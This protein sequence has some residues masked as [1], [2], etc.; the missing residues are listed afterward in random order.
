[1]SILENES[2]SEFIVPKDPRPLI[3]ILKDISP[4]SSRM[5][6][7]MRDAIT[8]SGN[9]GVKPHFYKYFFIFLIGSLL[10]SITL[11]SCSHPVQNRRR[12]PQTIEVKTADQII[13]DMKTGLR[14]SDEQEADIRPIIEEQVK[15][16]KELVKKYQ[17]RARLGMDSL[18][19]DLKDLRITT[20]NQLQ[21]FLT[22]EQMINYGYMQQEEDLRITGITNGKT[23]EEGGREKPKSGGRR[24]GRF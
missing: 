4:R 23:Q 2:P 18:R 21:Y 15:K 24:P 16:R 8:R 1:M 11:I 3:L 9:L 17:G 14:L 12:I 10:L 22:N 5:R 6:V 20:E 13:S 19:D 7:Q